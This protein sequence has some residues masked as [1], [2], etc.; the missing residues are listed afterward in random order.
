M[1]GTR[2][3]QS[4][5]L[6]PRFYWFLGML[7]VTGLFMWFSADSAERHVQEE[8]ARAVARNRE[9]LKKKEGQG[10]FDDA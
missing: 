8:Q 3:W 1:R 10:V 4:A 5:Q 7:M 2:D 9:R 6:D